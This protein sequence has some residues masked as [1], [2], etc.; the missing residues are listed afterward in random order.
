[1][2]NDEYFQ[3]LRKPKKK[4]VFRDIVAIKLNFKPSL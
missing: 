3:Q 1:M 4:L 2:F